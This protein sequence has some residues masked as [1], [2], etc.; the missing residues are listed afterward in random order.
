M[1]GTAGSIASSPGRVTG[2][3]A[4]EPAGAVS[5]LGGCVGAGTWSATPAVLEENMSDWAGLVGLT[6]S[7]AGFGLAGSF[8][9]RSKASPPC[10]AASGE[11]GGKGGSSVLGVLVERSAVNSDR[12]GWSEVT[13]RLGIS[14]SG[15]TGVPSR[16]I[17]RTRHELPSLP[18]PST[19]INPAL[20][21]RLRC[22]RAVL[23]LT[24]SLWP[25]VASEHRL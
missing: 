11:A 2:G 20:S 16:R 21:S 12:G 24:S 6:N 3:A 15:N 22:R 1:A 9:Y 4:V 19:S 13:G 5:R 25:I 10:P 18:Y 14:G 7:S 17:G 8:S 23:S